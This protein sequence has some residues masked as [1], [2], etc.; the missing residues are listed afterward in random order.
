MKR[1]SQSGGNALFLI[2]IAVALFAALAYAITQSGRGSGSVSREQGL[3]SVAQMLQYASG[4]EQAVQ[5]MRLVNNC[6]LAQI[7][8]ENDTVAGYENTLSP[9][10]LSCHVFDPAGGGQVWQNP[11]SGI[12]KIGNGYY[13]SGCYRMGRSQQV[14]G[15]WHRAALLMFLGG[16]TREQC[17]EINRRLGVDDYNGEPP[18]EGSHNGFTGFEYGS[19][20]GYGAGDWGDEGPESQPLIEKA[21]G[22]LDMWAD[23]LPETYYTYFKVVG[24][25]ED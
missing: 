11:P 6:S 12:P 2:L 9:T 22:C 14:N 13:F 15:S 18:K 19:D 7:S 4:I 21:E 8:F 16:L 25:L 5:R 10:D 3:L 20:C 17:L 1:G 24:W 23:S